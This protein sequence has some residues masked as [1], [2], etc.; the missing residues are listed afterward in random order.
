MKKNI[1]IVFLVISIFAITSTVQSCKKEATG[2]DK[3]LFDKSKIT[4]GYTYY[5]LSTAILNKTSGSGHSDAKLATRYNSEAAKDLDA[6]GKVKA[7]TVFAENSLIVKELY[8]NSSTATGY[9]IMYKKTGDVNADS[10]GWVWAVYSKDGIVKQAAS[11]KGSG[12]ISCHAGAGNIDYSLM[13]VSF[14]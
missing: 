9:A 11:K 2:S 10:K 8:D 3:D 5:K 14:P 6:N 13:N 7:G 4:T 12:C 1:I